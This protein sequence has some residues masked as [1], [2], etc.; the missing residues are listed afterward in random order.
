MH[1]ELE[2]GKSVQIVSKEE[3]CDPL[4]LDFTCASTRLIV[5]WLSENHSKF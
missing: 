5:F 2:T 3:V 4:M 1:G